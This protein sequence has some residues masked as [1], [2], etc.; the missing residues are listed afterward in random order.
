ME[1]Q[2]DR[3]AWIESIRNGRT[4]GSG[5]TPF[6][7][8]DV[9]TGTLA[10]KEALLAFAGGLFVSAVLASYAAVEI[11]LVDDIILRH[12]TTVA[13]ADGQVTAE[14]LT[15]GFAQA[16]DDKEG[17]GQT[18]AILA[19]L[20][21]VGLWIDPE[22]RANVLEL[23]RHKNDFAHFRRW[24]PAEFTQSGPTSTIG[25][26]ERSRLVQPET[27]RKYAEHAIVTAF[28]VWAMPIVSFTPGHP[29]P[30]DWRPTTVA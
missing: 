6:E 24:G 21:T 15:E 7:Q 18:K 29:P 19:E 12:V 4:V 10:F 23:G 20:T 26:I 17:L 5:L 3:V 1:T 2:A 8:P 22:L 27:R 30:D 9:G 16:L 28:D 14:S 25:K 13:F 11:I